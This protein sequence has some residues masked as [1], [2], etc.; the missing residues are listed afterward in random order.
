[1]LGPL[2]S[3]HGFARNQTFTLEHKADHSCTLVSEHYRLP[4]L[5]LLTRPVHCVRCCLYLHLL[6]AAVPW[7]ALLSFENLWITGAPR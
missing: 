6:I 1:M 5:N 4:L 2:P 7:C 3:Q